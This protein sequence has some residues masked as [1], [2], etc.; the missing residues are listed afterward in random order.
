MSGRAFKKTRMKEGGGDKLQGK[1]KNFQ[2]A[3]YNN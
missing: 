3:K 2:R 1:R